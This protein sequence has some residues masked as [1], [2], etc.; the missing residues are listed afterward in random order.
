M[1]RTRS[2]PRSPF[3]RTLLLLGDQKTEALSLLREAAALNPSDKALKIASDS[4]AHPAPSPGPDSTSASAAAALAASKATPAPKTPETPTDFA[5]MALAK[6]AEGESAESLFNA[7]N[8]PEERQ[9]AAV[10]QAYI[11]IQL[12]A[13]RRSAAKKDCATV[14]TEMDRLGREDKNLPFT[15]Q[16]FG[17]FMKGARFQ[18]YLGAVESLCGLSKDAKRRWAE[19]AKMAPDIAAPDFAFPVVAAQ[20]LTSKSNAAE[21]AS[22]LDKIGRALE[23]ATNESKGVLYYSKGILLL[24]KGDERGAIAAFAEGVEAPDREFSQYLNK[25]A[26]VEAS[27]AGPAH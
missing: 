21:L 12:Q 20:N 13:L 5:M 27:R 17:V 23:A 7:R 11:E 22:L 4:A 19:A 26:L 24:A 14:R 1:L 16:G 18:Y 3:G 10:L 9:P 25:S 6:T 8:F 2:R 15:L